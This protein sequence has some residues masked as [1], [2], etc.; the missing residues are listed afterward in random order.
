MVAM[1]TTVA[2]G[3]RN[4][5]FMAAYFKNTYAYTSK[6]AHI[7]RGAWRSGRSRGVPS[8]VYGQI[9]GKGSWGRNPQKL[10]L[11]MKLG[12]NF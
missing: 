9:L 2:T 7:F 11:N 10:K 4:F 8:M 12:Y 6:W 5:H 3:P 1:A